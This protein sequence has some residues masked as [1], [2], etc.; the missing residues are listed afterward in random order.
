MKIGCL[1]ILFGSPEMPLAYP[2]PPF[3]YTLPYFRAN[4]RVP[5]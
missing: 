5:D 2:K 3:V 1:F 4:Q